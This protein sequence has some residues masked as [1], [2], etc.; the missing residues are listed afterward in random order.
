MWLPDKLY[1]LMPYIYGILGIF[2]LYKFDTA[3]GYASGVLLLITA[4]LV[5]VMRRDYRRIDAKYR[6]SKQ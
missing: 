2:T 6:D 1:E 3:I 4:G 5:W